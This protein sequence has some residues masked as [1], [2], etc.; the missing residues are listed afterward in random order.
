LRAPTHPCRPC[1]VGGLA[2]SVAHTLTGITH[3]LERLGSCTAESTASPILRKTRGAHLFPDVYHILLLRALGD[4]V[5]LRLWLIFVHFDLD[6]PQDCAS[7]SRD[8]GSCCREGAGGRLLISRSSIWSLWP[9]LALIVTC[10][11]ISAVRFGKIRSW[12]L[13]TCTKAMS[14]IA[15]HCMQIV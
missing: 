13:L 12:I 7:A 10:Y 3:K 4:M 2:V 8:P 6:L 9:G 5:L 14:D 15:M 11:S 1:L